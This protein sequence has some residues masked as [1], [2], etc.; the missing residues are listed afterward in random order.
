MHV[1]LNSVAMAAELRSASWQLCSPSNIRL[2]KC[3]YVTIYLCFHN[4]F[5]PNAINNLI[6][7]CCFQAHFMIETHA[8]S[9][10]IQSLLY[11]F[12]KAMISDLAPPPPLGALEAV[13]CSQGTWLTFNHTSLVILKYSH[14]R[15]QLQLL[16]WDMIMYGRLCFLLGGAWAGSGLPVALL[17]VSLNSGRPR[18]SQIASDGSRVCQMVPDCPISWYIC[19]GMES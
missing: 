1:G 18:W 2:A 16:S 19:V 6:L 12:D 7:Q 8:S 11:I 10:G 17:G 14:L 3:S 15:L 4:G 9:R 5:H 13:Q